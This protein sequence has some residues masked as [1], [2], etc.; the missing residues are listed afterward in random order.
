[1]EIAFYRGQTRLGAVEAG[2]RG[3]RC[4]DT[5]FGQGRG[6]FGQA[7]DRRFVNVAKRIPFVLDDPF[8]V[9]DPLRRVF[10][11]SRTRIAPIAQMRFEL[12]DGAGMTFGGEGPALENVGA[13]FRQHREALFDRL[14]IPF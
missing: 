14:N 12:G 6:L 8:E 4:R 1:M 13:V 9:L 2:L 10:L 11:Q 5:D 3:V 7:P